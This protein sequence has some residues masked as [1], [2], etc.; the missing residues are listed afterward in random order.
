MSSNHKSGT[1]YSSANP[2]ISAESR[3]G[4]PRHLI[5][6]AS[7]VVILLC[8]ISTSI[9]Y[10]ATKPREETRTPDGPPTPDKKL[11]ALDEAIKSEISLLENDFDISRLSK[12]ESDIKQLKLDLSG[13]DPPTR[14]KFKDSN[15]KALQ[16]IADK[17]VSK[18]N[19]M[20]IEEQKSPIKPAE[21]NE[22]L[23][24]NRELLVGICDL[25]KG[26]DIQ[27]KPKLTLKAYQDIKKSAVPKIAF[28]LRFYFLKPLHSF[29]TDEIN[30]LIKAIP[31]VVGLEGDTEAPVFTV[32]DDKSD[33]ILTKIYRLYIDDI[34]KDF[35]ERLAM[36]HEDE[37]DVLVNKYAALHQKY[38]PGTESPFKYS[39]E[40]SPNDHK[41]TDLPQIPSEMKTETYGDLPVETENIETTGQFSESETKGKD[42]EKSTEGLEDTDMPQI[43][44]TLTSERDTGDQEIPE[45]PNIPKQTETQDPQGISPPQPE[46]VEEP[47]EIKPHI[48]SYKDRFKNFKEA[49]AELRDNKCKGVL[50]EAKFYD[51]ILN[52]DEF[53]RPPQFNLRYLAI[54]YSICNLESFTNILPEE[55]SLPKVKPFF[56][57]LNSSL[58]ESFK[59]EIDSA[60]GND[61]LVLCGNIYDKNELRSDR[62][63]SKAL[64]NCLIF[65]IERT[66]VS[67]GDKLFESEC[68]GALQKI[69]YIRAGLSV[70]DD[71]KEKADCAAV[72]KNQFEKALEHGDL[73]KAKCAYDIWQRSLYRHYD[74]SY[75]NDR[76]D[77]FGNQVAKEKAELRDRIILDTG[78]L[79]ALLARDIFREKIVIKGNP[80]ATRN[81][82]DKL[83]GTMTKIHDQVRNP[84]TE[85]KF[86]ADYKRIIQLDVLNECLFIFVPF[87]YRN[88]PKFVA[89]RFD[90]KY[91][92][93]D[94]LYTNLLCVVENRILFA[95]N[96]VKLNL[97][98]GP[99]KGSQ[100]KKE[101][102]FS[103]VLM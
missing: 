39:D 48:E 70:S 17:C 76:L 42:D 102:L 15:L 34:V 59:G 103:Q 101:A 99:N 41:E 88:D 90:T 84:E 6:L 7:A 10:F 91:D 64:V 21:V 26:L 32:D 24:R 46:A 65:G 47:V 95:N 74:E 3:N 73:L 67:H 98:C 2:G 61:H 57:A 85:K 78:S 79:E 52:N 28:Y 20:E 89:L 62:T 29:P 30:N 82:I 51:F 63:F 35:S 23:E 12:L 75:M 69:E 45:N 87:N 4:L 72:F 54:F 66:N 77:E 27:L 50:S 71:L 44:T 81:N 40:D 1:G 19:E 56:E 83:K 5:I 14:S 97:V 43:H 9:I 93:C 13:A 22:D 16:D 80:E 58:E 60:R 49:F 68:R 38:G 25:A 36:V 100:T 92:F 94:S 31:L 8:G 53:E 37:G 55:F 33:K 18:I 86:L 96:L 11:T